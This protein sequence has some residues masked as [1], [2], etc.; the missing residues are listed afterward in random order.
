AE[1]PDKRIKSEYEAS[2]PVQFL[3]HHDKQLQLE[4]SQKDSLKSL[5]KEL[6]ALQKPIFSDVEKIVSDAQKDRQ[7]GRDTGDDPDT[8][9]GGGRGGRGIPESVRAL[10]VKLTD[11]QSAFNDRAR[12]HLS[13]G[14][15]HIADSLK[16]IYDAE[17]RDRENKQRALVVDVA[18]AN[19]CPLCAGFDNVKRG[20]G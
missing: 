11:I 10:L 5:H 19:G 16:T 7:Q 13:D 9:A 18:D 15:R 20:G 2:D 14:Q 6:D 12:A 1:S 17:L 4:K 3:L 8:R